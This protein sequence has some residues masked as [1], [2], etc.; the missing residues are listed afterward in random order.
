[1]E[2]GPIVVVDCAR[3][4]R[5]DVGTVDAIA[6][7]TLAARQDG[8]GLRLEDAPPSLCGLLELCGLSRLLLGLEA[9]RQAEEREEARGVEEEGDVRDPSL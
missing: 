5:P 2:A 7:L 1:M 3:L 4:D 9:G 8:I 6:R